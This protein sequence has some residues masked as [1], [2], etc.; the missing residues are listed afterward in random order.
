MTEYSKIFE[1]FLTSVN[2]YK[3]DK[4]Y[5]EDQVDDGDRMETYLT[6]FLIKS[7]PTFD[8]C[9][10]DLEDR[11]DTT[12]IFNQDLNTDEK[13]ILSDLMV[14]E[15]LKSELNDIRQMRLRLTDDAFK[16]YAEANNMKEKSSLLNT[17]E[18]SADKRIVR[19]SQKNLNFQ[20]DFG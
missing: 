15:W 20:E 19:Y 16:S 14:Y 10:K 9:K 7:I 13:V 1:L 8:K 3:I 17:M 2:D 4:L 6:P 11:D 12:R 18:E 5:A